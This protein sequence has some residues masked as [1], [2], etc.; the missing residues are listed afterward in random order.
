MI[1][2][3]DTHSHLYEDEF[4]EDRGEAIQRLRERHVNNVYLP[5]ID[6]ESID[7]MLTLYKSDEQLFHIMMGLHP[8][9]VKEDYKEAIEE[10]WR[11]LSGEAICGIGEIGID[12]YWDKEYIKEQTDAFETQ[13][14]WAIA[15]GLPIVI[16]TRKAFEE[17]F[18]SLKKFDKKKLK[19]IFHCYSGS[20]E[21]AEEIFKLGDFSLG[22]GGVLT[23][24]NAGLA[25]VVKEIPL[26]KLVLETD[27]PYL[28][29]APYRG[30]RNESSYV[31]FIAEKLAEIKGM[32]LEEIAEM[33]SRNARNIF[34]G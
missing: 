19:G 26:E 29:P 34:G 28:T 33:T 13:V 1:D 24:K 32:S 8:T 16:H 9:S 18:Q 3:T 6:I 17:T 27:C 14:D 10:I 12:L 31:F 21:I 2:L 20:K 11:R 15:H 5:N 25:Q 4:S 7:K 30:Q 22:I 23:F